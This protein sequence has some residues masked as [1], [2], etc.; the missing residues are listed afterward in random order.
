MSSTRLD[1]WLRSTTVADLISPRGPLVG[2]MGELAAVAGCLG[3]LVALFLPWYELPVALGSGRTDSMLSAWEA[4][5]YADVILAGLAAFGLACA[6]AARLLDLPV[7]HVPLAAAGWAALAVVLYSYQ[8]PTFGGGAGPL[9]GP[10]AI[11]F[12]VALCATGA[13]VLGSQLA[14]VAGWVA[15]GRRA[16]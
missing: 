12:F 16:G 9:P 4:F 8:R 3:V 7:L 5:R 2:L 1:S 14:F 13:I 6:A 11:G 15:A 10:P